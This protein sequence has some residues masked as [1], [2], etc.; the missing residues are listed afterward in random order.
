MVLQKKPWNCLKCFTGGV[1][2]QPITFLV[3]AWGEDELGCDN[4]SLDIGSVD[5][6]GYLWL[7]KMQEVGNL[8][9]Q[10]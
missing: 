9:L 7:Q 3:P 5:H 10:K 8:W 2:V 6:F 1:V 4:T